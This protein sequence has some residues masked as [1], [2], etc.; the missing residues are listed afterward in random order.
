MF[1]LQEASDQIALQQTRITEK[2]EIR[3]TP[4]IPRIGHPDEHMALEDK[5]RN[6]E[7]NIEIFNYIITVILNMDFLFINQLFLQQR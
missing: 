3:Q 1:Q 6:H 4:K 2:Q 7:R 5:Q